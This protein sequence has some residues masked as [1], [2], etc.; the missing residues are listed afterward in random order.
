MYVITAFPT[1]R[2]PGLTWDEKLSY[3]IPITE[4]IPYGGPLAPNCCT[5][6]MILHSIVYV[7]SSL[8]F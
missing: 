4:H 2:S 5:V 8:R 7:S 1:A 3:S 6:Q